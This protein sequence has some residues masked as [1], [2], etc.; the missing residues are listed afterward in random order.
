[1]FLTLII[2][3]CKKEEI[4]NDIIDEPVLN[5]VSSAL[6]FSLTTGNVNFY[7]NISY[8][9]F[10][11][12]VFDVFLPNSE[13]PTSLVIFIHGGGFTGGD[14]SIPYTNAGFQGLIDNLLAQNIA[15]ATI[16]YRFLENNETE[17][18]LKPLNDSKRA[19]QFM[20][21]YSNSLNLNKSKVALIG[22][23]AGAG[24]S[25]WIGFNDDMADVN[26]TDPILRETTRIQGI[27]A[28]STQSSY[29]VLE[30]HN[31]TFAEYQSLGLNFDTILNLVG[32]QT[33]LQ[34]YGVNTMSELNT[35]ETQQD[36][37]KLDMLSLLSSDDPEFYLSNSNNPYIYPTTNTHI[38]HHPL[39]SKTL[40]DKAT[41]ENVSTVVYLPSMN[42][43]TRNGES[44]FDFIIRKI[45]T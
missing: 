15:F 19:L 36:R 3:S 16:N 26:N 32:E 6:P 31:S 4:E 39:H 2:I 40:M 42:I 8:G 21:Y 7:Q 13:S 11:R 35:T 20:R 9:N 27:V 18:I 43:D 14:K 12:N 17:G 44:I 34:F 23:S 41:V 10:E 28:T 38:L 29:D 1:M 37:V 24:T 25:L 5:L 33:L 22:S 30:W 45:G